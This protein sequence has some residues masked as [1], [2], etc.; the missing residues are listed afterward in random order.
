MTVRV[1]TGHR[2]GSL[3]LFH[4]CQVT[5]LRSLAAVAALLLLITPGLAQERTQYVLAISWQPAFCEGRPNR[6]ECTSQ[7]GERFDAT[8]FA[9]H[10]LWPQRVDYC[11]VARDQQYADQDG[12]WDTLPDPDL[13]AATRLRLKEAMPGTQSGLDR[14]EWIKHG[15]CYGE[16]ADAYFTDALAM[17]QAVNASPVRDL[18]AGN[19][20][21]QLTQQQV[22][23]AFDT[24]FGK[25]AGLRVRLACDRDGDR[26]L[27][28]EL[29]IGLT[30]EIT[31][32]DAYPRLT[33]A[34]R[35]TDGGC[36]G[37]IVDAVGL[38]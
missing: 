4:A 35:P 27:I 29:T 7:T 36:D 22:R 8:H 10:G 19:I 38:Q 20:G 2:R 30:G 17:L 6:D 24:A 14:H 26:R 34:A 5:M 12:D 28:T 9:L 23:D 31:G 32:P 1:D 15:T 3:R 37:G 11:D 18:F 21:K 13:S 16:P 25:G 33:M